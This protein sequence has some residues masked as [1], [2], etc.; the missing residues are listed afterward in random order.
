MEIP[1]KIGNFLIISSLITPKDYTT[2]IGSQPILD[3]YQK[4]YIPDSYSDQEK[5]SNQE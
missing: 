4:I 2:S 3:R 1:T 5:N